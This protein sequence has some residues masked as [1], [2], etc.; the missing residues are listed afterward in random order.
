MKRVWAWLTVFSM[1][2]GAVNLVPAEA[3]DAAEA[4]VEESTEGTE[5][6]ASVEDGEEADAAEDT[7]E[8]VAADEEAAAEAEQNEEDL[9]SLWTDDSLNEIFHLSIY[10]P[11][12]LNLMHIKS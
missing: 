11:N 12:Y 4:A 6:T 8:A 10:F 9:L 5:E 7:G 3:G 2:L 1:T